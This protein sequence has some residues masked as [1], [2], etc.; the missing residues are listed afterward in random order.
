[1][2]YYVNSR[3]LR[4]RFDTIFALQIYLIIEQYNI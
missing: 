2:E 4:L 1:M 3:E